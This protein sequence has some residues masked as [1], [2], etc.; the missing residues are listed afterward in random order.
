MPRFRV[1]WQDREVVYYEAHVEAPS[2]AVA[3][4]RAKRGEVPGQAIAAD[5][6][7]LCALSAEGTS[8]EADQR[9][10]DDR[11]GQRDDR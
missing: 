9:P 5:T 10:A 3:Y 6:Q 11:G 1:T 4:R 8:D 2:L 7:T